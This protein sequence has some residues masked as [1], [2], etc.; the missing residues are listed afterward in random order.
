MP[1]SWGTLTWGVDWMSS[2]RTQNALFMRVAV[3]ANSPEG[4]MRKKYATPN[5]NPNT[6]P[7]C[8]RRGT[9]TSPARSMGHIAGRRRWGYEPNSAWHRETP[10][11]SC[12]A[13][14]RVVPRAL[15]RMLT[16]GRA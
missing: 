5:T 9:K 7:Q 2:R 1:Y 13:S 11:G 6:R 12:T 8:P 15:L 4:R 10:F 3:S 16:D 14:G